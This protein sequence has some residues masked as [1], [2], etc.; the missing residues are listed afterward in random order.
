MDLCPDN[1]P[2]CA[3]GLYRKNQTSNHKLIITNCD[4]DCKQGVRTDL[5]GGT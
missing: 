4:K 1:S 2:F 3:Y 5:K